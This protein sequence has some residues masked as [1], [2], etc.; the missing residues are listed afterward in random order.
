AEYRRG[1]RLS[2]DNEPILLNLGIVYLKEDL[3]SRALPYFQHVLAMDPQ[4]RQTRQLLDVC[5]LYTGQT[6]AAL[7]D[8]KL[9]AKE[10]PHNEQVLFLLGF[11]YL[12][13]G[14][15]KTAKTIFHRMFQ[16]AGP[17]QTE[18]LLGKA[19]YEAAIFPQ[20]E[21]SFLEVLRLDPRFP[22]IHLALGKVYISERRNEDAIKQL[23][24]ALDKNPSNEDANYYLGS[25]LVQQAHYK[26]G[27]PY[28]EEAKRLKPDSYGVYLYLGKAKLHAGQAAE[29]VR[30]LRKAVELNP[31]DTSAEYTLAR[32]LKS[33][34]Q[35]AAARK[36][37]ERVH[38]L[39][40]RALKEAKIPGIR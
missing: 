23:K 6:P 2:P 22:G 7:R 1:L 20:A 37:F 10:N 34:G 35:A 8:L 21:E 40:D 9:L 39:N 36:A 16:D 25:L 14:D 15:S 18:F 26:Q 19:S 11:A 29:A 5:R 24:K 27:I 12:K 31:D 38:N 33:S 3:H 4:N 13:S 17:G 30:L 28:L 32:A